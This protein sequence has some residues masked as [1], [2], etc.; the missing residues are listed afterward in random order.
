MRLAK[1]IFLG[2]LAGLALVLAAL[3]GLY[4]SPLRQDLYYRADPALADLRSKL[5]T[6]QDWLS[7]A[8]ARI[9]LQGPEADSLRAEQ[10]RVWRDYKAW[11]SR[12]GELARAHARPSG[13]A[14]PEWAYSLRYWD[15]PAAL[16][17]ALLGAGLAALGIRNRYRPARIRPGKAP[18]AAD[19]AASQAH[20]QA[21]SRFEEAVKQVAR[22]SRAETPPKPAELPPTDILPIQPAAPVAPLPESRPP[23]TKPLPTVAPAV[24]PPGQDGRETRLFQIGPG[25][26]EAP[27]D[28]PPAMPDLPMEDEDAPGENDPPAGPGPMPPTTEVERVERRKEEVLKLARKGMTSSEISRRLRISQDQVEIIIRMRREKG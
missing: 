8:D 14:F 13:P 27:A 10:A 28:R 1:P 9:A 26:G 23:D 15:G 2:A 4:V 3:A 5:A 11:R 17:A 19:P 22:I 18:R 25:W 24:P 6:Y 20:A 7:Q 12:M 21:I 16:A